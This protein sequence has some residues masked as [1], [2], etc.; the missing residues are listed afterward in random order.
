MTISRRN[1]LKISGTAALFGAIKAS[2]PSG[3]HAAESGPEVTRAVLGYIALTDAA[4]LIIAKEKGFFAKHGMPDVEV[5]K[6]ASLG[7]HARQPGAG[8]AGRRHRRRAHPDA[9]ALPDAPPGKVTQNNQPVP[10]EILAAAQTNGQAISVAN[11]YADSSSRRMRSRSSR[12]CEAK[13]ANG[14]GRQGR[15]DLPRRHSRPV[16]P[17]LAGR[18][19]H[20]PGQGRPDH[21]GAAAADGGEHEGRHHGRLLRGRAVE[22]P[23]GQPE[24]RLHRR[25]HRRDLERPPGEDLRACAPTGS[26]RTRT[27]RRR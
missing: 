9:D 21:R 14:Q 17:L 11:E 27:R 15:H 16:D 19:R 23:A 24:D 4:P 5:A 13:K 25:H 1:V 18:R 22:R 26:S 8:P 12:P 7:R 3:V 2:F 6:Q 10:M 20:R